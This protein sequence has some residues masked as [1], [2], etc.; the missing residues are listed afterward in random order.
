[1]GGPGG[2]GLGVKDGGVAREGQ[3]RPGWDGEQYSPPLAPRRR[4][5]RPPRSLTKGRAPPRVVQMRGRR[6]RESRSI[7]QSQE[8]MNSRARMWNR[9]CPKP[10][11]L[12]HACVCALLPLP[13][14]ERPRSSASPPGS[15]CSST[16]SRCWRPRWLDAGTG[17]GR[18]PGAEGAGRGAGRRER[19][20]GFPAGQGHSAPSHPLPRCWDHPPWE[21]SWERPGG[22]LF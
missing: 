22:L 12:S 4:R 16:T 6:L 10:K 9:V 11:P 3:E 13:G 19:R 14:N 17:A 15:A 7:A 5:A 8:I 2:P 20:S 21:A 1:M 18:G